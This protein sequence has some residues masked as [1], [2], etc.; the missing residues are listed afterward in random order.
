MAVMSGL[1]S[2]LATDKQKNYI[3][4]MLHVADKRGLSYPTIPE[5]AKR[6]ETLNKQWGTLNKQE[7]SIIIEALQDLLGF[8]KTKKEPEP[9]KQENQPEEEPK[10]KFTFS[11]GISKKVGE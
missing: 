7:A 3:K 2:D 1:A 10:L 6:W 8:D 5:M 11:K 9:A 4:K